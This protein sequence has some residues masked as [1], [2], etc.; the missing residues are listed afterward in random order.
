MKG[1]V[2]R[3]VLEALCKD[4]GIS[5][6]RDK[7]A[8]CINGHP[9]AMKFSVMGEQNAYLF[10]NIHREFHILFC[11]GISP[12]GGAHAWVLTQEHHECLKTQH[13][14]AKSDQGD[15]MIRINPANPKKWPTQNQSGK[16]ADAVNRL[17]EITA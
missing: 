8:F 7:E 4:A 1:E 9:V 16:V 3:C 10:Q 12:N 15:M 14:G 2:G 5:F 17:K 13:K 11:L 6:T